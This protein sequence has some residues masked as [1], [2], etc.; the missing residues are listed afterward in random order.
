MLDVERDGA[1]VTLRMNR[2][3]VGNALSGD[4]AARMF[5]ALQELRRDPGVRVLVLTGAGRTFSAG[6]DLNHMKRMQQASAEENIRDAERTGMLFGILHDFPRPVI[7]VVN[8]P[9]RGGGV[10]LVAAC[11]FAIA[12]TNANF[13]FT[14]V[15]LG[16]VPALI[17]PFVLR[18]MGESRMRR[19]FLTGETF[20]AVQAAEWGLL[21]RA[22]P[23]EE[24]DAAVAELMGTLRCCA[25]EAIGH[26]K[27]LVRCV[28][29]LPHNEILSFTARLIAELRASPEAQEGIA[30]FLEKR[31]PRWAKEEE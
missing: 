26:V 10:G 23:S 29:G 11:D 3:E 30:A 27:N 4:L 13:A 20:G 17:S 9:A 12:S 14:E 2:P 24:L 21:D 8:G 16:V 18:K 5:E 7:A 6:A 22:V 15:R 31:R 19:L 25:P 28:T 1:R